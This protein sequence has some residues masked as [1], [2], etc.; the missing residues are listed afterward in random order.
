M[1][2]SNIDKHEMIVISHCQKGT[3]TLLSFTNDPIK[4]NMLAIKVK[5][6]NALYADSP[7][8]I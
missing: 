7:S 3:G 6:N 1:G 8:N 4:G 5:I 2:L